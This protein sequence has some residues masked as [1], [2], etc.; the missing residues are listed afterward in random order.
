MDPSTGHQAE[1]VHI[2]LHSVLDQITEIT[3]IPVV[4]TTNKGTTETTIETEYA[5]K[6]QNTTKET[7]TIKA[8]MITIKIEI[9]LTTEDG[10][11][12]TSTTETSQRH[13]SYLNTLTKIY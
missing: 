4:M 10:Q 11:I 1:V 3:A 5:N 8:G 12:S 9:D 2:T 7:K 6:T 13:K